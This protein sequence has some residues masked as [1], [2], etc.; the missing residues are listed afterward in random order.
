MFKSTIARLERKF[1]KR[2]LAGSTAD[3][4]LKMGEKYL[5]PAFRR[6]AAR[7]PAYRTLLK[8]AGVDPATIG[9]VAE[10]KARCPLL[11]KNNT[12][13]RFDIAHLMCDDVAP[14]DLA[15]V[16]TSSG[17]GSGG[18]ALGMSTRK[19]H[20]GSSRLIDIGLEMAFDIDACRTLLINCLPMG[21]MF[22]SD[23]VC[24]ANVSVRE[25]MACA[26]VKQAGSLFEQIILV[27]DPLFY[28]RFCD[29][30]QAQGVDWSRF[31]VNAI[32]GEETFPEAFRNYLA[33]VL[34]VDLD[35]PAAGLIGSSMGV[36]E[37]GLNLFSESRE[38][39]ALRRACVRNPA[40]LKRLTGVDSAQAPVP[41]FMTFNPLRTII[42]VV[43]AD[44]DGVGDLVVTVTDETTPVPL[45][46]YNTGDRMQLL[47]AS[48]F[49]AVADMLP[50]GWTP[51]RAPMVALHGRAK[52]RLPGGG[53]VDLFKETLYS[54]PELAAPLTGAHRIRAEDNHVRWEVQ[55]IRGQMELDQI[56]SRLQSMLA[57]RL[58]HANVEVAVMGYDEFPHGKTIDYERKFVYWVPPA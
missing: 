22:N 58:K 26:I 57:P 9:S 16:L 30:S 4:L 7:S 28:K 41:T 3:Q 40:L 50:Q 18:F 20:H 54:V 34:K 46:R 29:Y 25:D 42:E 56:A 44:S 35:D 48:A 53:H 32:I 17:H 39:V 24:V 36:G 23:A 13:K 5:L 43:N 55:A 38:T 21:V 52:D 1:I 8:E 51:P 49:N 10:F 12:F 33:G 6:A 47:D 11:E 27:G 31:R 15:S 2:K 14:G 37:L 45:M 19:Q